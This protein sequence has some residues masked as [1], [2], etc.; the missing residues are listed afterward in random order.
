M[1]HSWQ[2][3][4][5]TEP[6]TCTRCGQ[7]E[8][9]PLGHSFLWN[10]VEQASCS[11]A[12]IEEGVCPVC[13][14]MEHREIEKLPHTPDGDWVV[15]K[16][17]VGGAEGTQVRYCAVCGEIAEEETY[18]LSPEEQE[19]YFKQG[20]KTYTYDE[21]ARHP[22][23]YKFQSAKFTGKVIQIIEDGDDIVMRLNITKGRYSWSDT[24]YVQYLRTDSSEGRILED[25]IITVYG[26]MMGTVTYRSSL[27]VPV[28]IPAILCTYVDRQ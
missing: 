22:D 10:A 16:E 24:I 28:T 1:G 19:A 3:A 25:D 13:G 18:H 4:S 2:N 17:A 27:R 11:K 5:C 26:L 20:C 12:G 8:G 14:E 9:N 23:D 15:T 6:K 21:I 7:T